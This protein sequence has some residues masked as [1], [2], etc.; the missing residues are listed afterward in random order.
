MKV[1][2]VVFPGS[3]C[4]DDTRRYFENKKDEVF[5]IWHKESDIDKYQFDV[6]VIPGGFAFGDRE[7]DKA[8][9]YYIINPGTLACRS[10][11]SKIILEANERGKIIVGICNG[12]QI[13]INLGLLPGRLELNDNK[14]FHCQRV[15]C[16]LGD[17]IIFYDVSNSFGNYQFSGDEINPENI[18]LYYDDEDYKNINGSNYGIAGITNDKNN[19]FGVMPHPERTTTNY[20]FYDFITE[21]IIVKQ[22]DKIS[23]SIN[24]LMKSEHISYKSTK[25]YLKDMY[26]KGKHVV[27]GPGE[28][29]GIVDIGGGYCLALRIESHNHPISID[30]YNGAA[31]GV[32]GILRDIFTMG[33][34]PIAIC[35]F[36]R[37][38]DRHGDNFLEEVTSGIADYANCF[39]VANV[40]GDWLRSNNYKDNPLLN[41]ACFGIVKK[42]NIIYGN[43]LN[44]GSL[45]IYVGSRTGKDGIGGADMA[46]KSFTKDTNFAD[47]KKNIQ[48]GDAYLE[49]LLL[50]ACLEIVD[51]KLA[52]GMQDMGAG[53]ILCSTIEVI[54]R[55]RVKTG[56]NLGCQIFVNN[57]PTKCYLDH[58]D[59]LIS[60]S[61]ERMLIVAREENKEAIFKIFEKWDLEHAVIGQVDNS[62]NYNVIDQVKEKNIYNISMNDF[63]NFNENWTEKIKDIEDYQYEEINSSL[64]RMY[65]C[66]IGGRSKILSRDNN[67]DYSILYIH[68]I[69]KDLIITWSEDFY[70]CYKNITDN[71]FTPLGLVNCLNYGHPGDSIGNLAKYVK[72][73]TIKCKQFNVPVL[74]GNVSL[75]NATEGNSIHPSP[76][77]VMVGISCPGL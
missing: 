59:K 31:T 4:I 10:P 44:D 9:D 65:D 17:K 5:Y 72:E 51:N 55:G 22:K 69:D 23:E 76:I 75:Y 8:T 26:T 73:L 66:T 34:R 54:Q 1:A 38:S 42:E 46:S 64:F 36:I 37:I 43:A 60:E 6:L 7:Y 30:P 57:I 11:V 61:Q 40:G 33:A 48:I 20:H 71:K 16:T 63:S 74:G 39:G 58:C 35:D 49:K 2:I 53:G 56:K 50:E 47:L 67:I 77:L 18:F 68:E 15:K 70:T 12:F 62:G 13:L 3:N 24:R 25:K 41:V 14:R 52:E 27:Q 19:I 28:N 45:L 32:G 21:S 29:A